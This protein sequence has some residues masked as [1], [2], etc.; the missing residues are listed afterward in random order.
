MRLYRKFESLK[1]IR[2]EKL[3]MVHKAEKLLMDMGFKQFRVRCYGES[4]RIEL[5]QYERVCFFDLDIM[6]KVV[7]GFRKIGFKYVTLDLE[8]YKSFIR[9]Q[10]SKFE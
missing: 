1:K 8:G 10:K 5:D 4:A 2:E 6:N 3:R 9:E 7:M